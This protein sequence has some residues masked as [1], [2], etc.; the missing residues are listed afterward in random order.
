MIWDNEETLDKLVVQWPIVSI[1]NICT[2]TMKMTKK[3]CQVLGKN[4]NN[5]A[6]RPGLNRIYVGIRSN[7]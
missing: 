3:K 4:L 2:F 5:K 6:K 7:L 1:I